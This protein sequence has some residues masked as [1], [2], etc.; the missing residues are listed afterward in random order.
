VWITQ[1]LSLLDK[2]VVTQASERLLGGFEGDEIDR[3]REAVSGYPADIHDPQAS[4]A[5]PDDLKADDGHDPLRLF[6]DAQERTIGS[7]WIHSTQTGDR[8]RIDTRGMTLDST[9]YS[10][11]GEPIEI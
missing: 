10:P 1:R 9:H 2:T 11:Q 8:R 5:A 6:Q 3:V 4:I 7:E